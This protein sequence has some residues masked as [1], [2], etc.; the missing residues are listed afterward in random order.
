[1][2][3]FPNALLGSL[4]P[5]GWRANK[6]K[7][8]GVSSKIG[9]RPTTG[10]GQ[11]PQLREGTSHDKKHI[12]LFRL[13]LRSKEI[14]GPRRQKQT[15]GGEKRCGG[16]AHKIRA[17]FKANSPKVLTFHPYNRAEGRRR[18]CPPPGGDQGFTRRRDWESPGGARQSRGARDLVVGLAKTDHGRAGTKKKTGHLKMAVRTR[19]SG[20]RGD[21]SNVDFQERDRARVIKGHNLP[22]AGGGDH[23]GQEAW[24]RP[25][26]H[27]GRRWAGEMGPITA[28]K[29]AGIGRTLKI[30]K[31]TKFPRREKPLN[32]TVPSFTQSFRE[33]LRVYG[34]IVVCIVMIGADYERRGGRRGP[35]IWPGPVGVS[36]F[37]RGQE[38][39][40][41]T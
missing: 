36:S 31:T 8:G 26:R 22:R 27:R 16:T 29:G 39:S 6:P 38:V 4:G 5:I 11:P 12:F 18:A 40:K 14:S 32:G 19:K 13:Q 7:I 2:G 37:R 30:E 21:T 24:G 3:F 15:P 10:C 20:P 35:E 1:L 34:T 28:N 9:R 17:A 23:E 33:P 25:A 41:R